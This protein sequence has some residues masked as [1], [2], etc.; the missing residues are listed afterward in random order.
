MYKIDEKW[1]TKE[2]KN[3]CVDEVVIAGKKLMIGSKKELWR[4]NVYI[5][6]EIPQDQRLL[7]ALYD[8]D[9]PYIIKVEEK[10]APVKTKVSKP[11]KSKIKDESKDISKESKEVSTEEKE[12]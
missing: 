6:G 3:G 2:D 4:G 11:K 12:D 10:K 5:Q 1:F 7:K 9:K 8:M